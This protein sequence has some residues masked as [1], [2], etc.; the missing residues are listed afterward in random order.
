MH[1][2]CLIENRNQWRSLVVAV[3]RLGIELNWIVTQLT[4]NMLAVFRLSV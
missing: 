2:I 3:I 1:Q 4:Q